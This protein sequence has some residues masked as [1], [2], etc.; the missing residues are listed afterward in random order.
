MTADRTDRTLGADG[1]VRPFRDE[2]SGAHT[3]PEERLTIG[4]VAAR[5]G[6]A[7]SAIRHYES[8]GLLTS[9]R[10]SGNQR[11]YARTVLRRIAVI[12]AAQH[13]GLSLAEI[14]EAFSRF[15]PDHAPTKRDWARLAREWRPRL[16]RRIRELEQ[17]R[18]GLS[19]CVGCGCLSMRQCAIYNPDDALGASGPGARRVFPHPDEE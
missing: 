7:T 12:Q 9:V 4:E 3:S 11:R 16:D 1:A 10:T 14:S 19:M 17:V 18:D 15:P 2:S 13:V 5:A 6:V 8:R